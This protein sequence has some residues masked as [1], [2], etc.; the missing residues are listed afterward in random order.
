VNKYCPKCAS[1]KET[2]EFSTNPA[3]HDGLASYCRPCARLCYQ[4][5]RTQRLAA[6]KEYWAK[7]KQIISA[8]KKVEYQKV[9]HEI[10]A[11]RNTPEYKARERDQRMQ[12][13]FGITW[14]DVEQMKLTQG[15]QCAICEL[16]FD[17]PK[18]VMCVDHDHSTG[19]VRKLLCRKCNTGLGLF[20][21]ELKVLTSALKY[22]EA[23]K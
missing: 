11:K 10:A 1:D 18:V 17:L 12:R 23:H 8:N 3:R 4:E 19:K 5:N 9:K 6:K 21:D 15:N 22:L 14:A 7:N 13:E 20:R 2:S 16:S